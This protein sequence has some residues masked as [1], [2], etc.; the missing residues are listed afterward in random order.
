M[1]SKNAV[2]FTVFILLLALILTLLFAVYTRKILGVE[3]P[4]SQPVGQFYNEQ[5]N[6]IDVL[7]FGASTFNAA[8][9]PAV[10]W[11]ERGIASYN[12]ATNGQPVS[13]TYY[14]LREALDYQ[15]PSVVVINTNFFNEEKFNG[16]AEAHFHEVLDYMRLSINKLDAIKYIVTNDAEQSMLDYLFPFFRYHDRE[17]LNKSDFDIFFTTRRNLSMGADFRMSSASQSLPGNYM[18]SEYKDRFIMRDTFV[19]KMI[20]L[21][22]E[23]NV[24]VILA[25]PP[26]SANRYWSKD[27]HDNVLQFALESDV[28]F[29]DYNIRDYWDETGFN[30]KRDFIDTN[31]VNL[32]GGSKISV[33]FAHYLSEM[34]HLLDRRQQVYDSHW[35]D[36]SA[37]Y[38]Q[39]YDRFAYNEQIKHET[40]LEA[41]LEL[42]KEYDD[43][44]IFISAVGHFT[45]FLTEYDAAAFKALGLK[46]D[47]SKDYATHS[48]YAVIHNKSVIAEKC[49]ASRLSYTANLNS[50]NVSIRSSGYSKD[51]TSLSSNITINGTQR[52]PNTTGFNFVIYDK[53]L[54][55]IA[56]SAGFRTDN[57]VYMSTLAP[58]EQLWSRALQS[59]DTSSEGYALLEKLE[60]V[61]RNE[62]LPSYLEA[63]EGV[64][65]NLV[66]IVSV[67][68]DAQR[69]I[70]PIIHQLNTMGIQTD[71]TDKYGNSFISVYDVSS[72]YSYEAFS[73]EKL[74]KTID[75]GDLPIDIKV[76]SAG[77]QAGN[78]A[79]IRIGGREYAKNKRGLNIVIYDKTLGKVF[80]SF[81]V[82]TNADETFTIIR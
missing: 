59:L 7:F 49:S 44:Y 57:D 37:F 18:S 28:A 10:M 81:Y 25:R 1:M 63:L 55:K 68:D 71:L 53:Q 56:S 22:K 74:E 50:L 73:T 39:Y 4:T 30:E 45:K 77:N 23:R 17:T 67:R 8:F 32:I 15:N 21:C 24:Q 64:N 42:L 72:G 60:K 3:V 76:I 14:L 47:L 34:Y 33:H 48:Y 58:P 51:D 70:D 36:V 11:E 40:N 43:C 38:H 69:N 12:L 78:T 26:T 46:T 62:D 20:D 82:D 65:Q 35:D 5:K 66:F 6:S 75:A 9:I 54:N 27:K 16:T 61:R 80:D 2:R 31:H 29:I 41:Y 79:S 13:A 19:R 52:A